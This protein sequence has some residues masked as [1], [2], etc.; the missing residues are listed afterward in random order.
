[1]S[2]LRL[3]ETFAG[4]VS[5]DEPGG[6]QSA[7][8]CRIRQVDPGDAASSDEEEID[9]REPRRARNGNGA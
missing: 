7:L 6:Y 9:E 5:R 4:S 1:V 2:S 8:G 3:P